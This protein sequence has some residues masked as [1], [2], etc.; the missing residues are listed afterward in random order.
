MGVLESSACRAGAVDGHR[1]S[2]TPESSVA[3]LSQ[4]DH[5]KLIEVQD[6]VNGPGVPG[7]MERYYYHEYEDEAACTRCFMRVHAG[8]GCVA[9]TV[10]QN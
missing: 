3:R 10:P 5:M 4:G 6:R 9:A 1:C 7:A 8:G 2:C